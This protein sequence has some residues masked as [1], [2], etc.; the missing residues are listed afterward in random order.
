MTVAMFEK[1]GKTEKAGEVEMVENVETPVPAV[2]AG[3]VE[4]LVIAQAAGSWAVTVEALAR[5]AGSA[6]G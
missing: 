6:V 5:I 4:K 2:S 3:P 1:V